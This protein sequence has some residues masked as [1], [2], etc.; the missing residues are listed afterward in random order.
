MNEIPN[1]HGRTFARLTDSYLDMYGFHAWDGTA[2]FTVIRRKAPMPGIHDVAVP[3]PDDEVIFDHADW[4]D[5]FPW[6]A[7]LGLHRQTGHANTR[8]FLHN[9]VPPTNDWYR[10][11]EARTH[12]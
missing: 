6:A 8:D 2:R 12:A 9:I 4:K 7:S 1:L 3:L 11:Q 5:V 10:E